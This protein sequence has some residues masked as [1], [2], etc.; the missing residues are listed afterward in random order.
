MKESDE[1][2]T[3]NTAEH[4][5][6]DLVK[7]VLGEIDLDPCSP[8]NNPIIPA[9]QRFTIAYSCF[10][11]E[12]NGKVYMNPPFSN[13]LPFLERLCF[14]YENGQV[15]EAIACLKSGTQANKGTGGLILKHASAICQWG[16]GKSSR[17]AFVNAQGEVK[18]NS[19]FDC[20]LVY[21]GKN[22]RLFDYHFRQYGHV[23]PTQ[24]TIDVLLRS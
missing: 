5:V 16:A 10:N 3:P 6:I 15:P 14:F 9:K 20:I 4:P 23:M 1:W 19:D 12:W 17:L 2:Y 24:R 21:F 22:W 7:A 11:H 8:I 18:K 13:P